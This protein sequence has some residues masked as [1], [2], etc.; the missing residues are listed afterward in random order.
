MG[1]YNYTAP[2]EITKV[3]VQTTGV[4]DITGYGGQ[5]GAAGGG[6]LGANG[7]EEGGNFNLTAGEKL[8]IVAGGAGTN[9]YGGHAGGGGGGGSFVFANTG[10]GGTYMPLLVAGGGG[11]DGDYNSAGTAGTVGAPGTGAGGAAG[12]STKGGG[13]AGVKS[14][15]GGGSGK[16]SGG[17]GA[18]SAGGFVGGAGYKYN[19]IYSSGQGGFGGGGG[20]SADVGGGGGGGG[21]SG[22]NGGQEDGGGG[23]TSF[24]AGTAIAAQTVA[25]ANA[26]A[27][28]VL[29]AL[30]CYVSGTL[31]RTTRGEV[32]VEHLAI[33]DLAVTASGVHRPI[34]WLGHRAIDCRNHPRSGDV[35]PIRIAAH[36]FGEDSPSRDLYLSPGHP[37][38]VGADEDGAG[39]YLVP[40]MCL[41]NGTTIERAPVDEVT[42]WHVE[43]DQHDILLAEGLP[44][45]SYLDWGDRLFFTEGSDHA[46]HNPDFII[47]GLTGRCR[48]VAIDGPVVEAER[49]RLDTQFAS[50][51]AAASLGLAPKCISRFDNRGGWPAVRYVD[52][53]AGRLFDDCAF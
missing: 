52:A 20:G 16:F 33:G 35:M 17:G 43:L 45:E 6:A 46:L 27:G 39:G 53:A 28:K 36:A 12:N 11:G 29:V 14:A 19:G 42:Y 9:A 13:G 51:L 49:R 7:A 50:R 30:V 38:L 44:A 24:D 32:A 37:V 31:I 34:R 15:G 3:T 5:G 18:S 40:I 48:P 22:G 1:T 25:G 21:Y 10:P 41:I 8:E 2:G 26:G 23:G 4:Y 47:P